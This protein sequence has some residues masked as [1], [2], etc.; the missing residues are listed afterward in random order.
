MTHGVV[1]TWNDEEGFGVIDSDDTP[2]GCGAVFAVIQADGYRT[3]H[4]GQLVQFRFIKARQD[5]CDFQALE[6]LPDPPQAG[7]A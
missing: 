1:R 2:G 3:L 7:G 6:V 4:A 5:D